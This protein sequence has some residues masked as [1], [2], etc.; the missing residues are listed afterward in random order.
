MVKCCGLAPSMLRDWTP[1]GCPRS[2]ERPWSREGWVVGPLEE[3]HG[4]DD[5]SLALPHVQ[6]HHGALRVLRPVAADFEGGRLGGIQK[7]MHTKTR[8]DDAINLEEGV[9]N[10]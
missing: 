4:E 10:P 3:E 7:V 1:E 8:A 6:L 9:R 2:Q 5:P